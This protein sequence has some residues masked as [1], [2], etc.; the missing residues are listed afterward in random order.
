MRAPG[1]PEPDC[2][3][4]SAYGSAVPDRLRSDGVALLPAAIVLALL[5]YWGAHGGGYAPTT[6][7]PSALVVLGL[8]VA[9]VAGIGPRRLALSRPLLVALAA[10]AAYTA[11]S[12]L[13]IAWADAPGD[14]LEGADRTLLF[15]LLFALFAVLPWRGP[16]AL[17]ALSAFALGVGVLALVTLVRVGGADAAELF[18][19]GRLTSPT[20]YVNGSAALF[21]TGALVAAALASRREL[22]LLLR[23]LLMALATAAVQVAVLCVSRG[24]LFSLPIVLVLAIAVLP[25]RVRFALWALPVA[26]G[27]LAALPALL[28]VFQRFD[29]AEPARA[30]GVLA[31]AA[32][33]AAGTALPACA[34]VL[35]VGLAMAL[36]DRR[37]TVPDRVVRGA[38][39]VAAA[40]AVA[41]A[42]AG[43]AA[44]L[45]AT[46]GRPDRTIAD[47]WDRSQGY[48]SAAPGSSRF[49]LAGSNRPDFWRVS[50]DA[51]AARPLVGLGQD[52]WGEYYVRERHTDEQPRWTHSLEL[53]VLAHSGLVGAL[54]L[55]AFLAAALI[56]ALRGRGRAEPAARAAAAI[57]VLPLVVWTVHGSV[58]WFWEIPALSGP[59][60]AFL[61]LAG[62]LTNPPAREEPATPR[63]PRRDA[64]GALA[65]G[66]GAALVGAAVLLAALALA[67]PYLAER[68]VARAGETWRAA[69][70]AAFDR[71]DRARDLNPLSA[72][73]D[74][75][76]G[77]IALELGEPAIARR[78]FAAAL[79]REQ[80]N[81]F[82]AFARGLAASQ[83]G[84]RAAA[85]ADFLRARALDP[86]EPLVLEA[87]ERVRGARP[88]TAAEAFGSVRQNVERLK[89]ADPPD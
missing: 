35:A 88:L 2:R 77:A 7:L 12:Y 70:S 21:M 44:G 50:L 14:A 76:A 13:S 67:L 5:V 52:N 87:L 8:L 3:P 42:L 86:R 36:V 72:R 55:A 37:T 48:E 43:V 80:R 58:D 85:R 59:A 46:D 47:Y 39:R 28:D 62:A 56:A 71:L 79:E 26:G 57:A 19:D 17:A 16:S 81:W 29:A 63:A 89:G 75:T 31:A 40:L 45:T 11:L 65:A 51:F 54:L 33:H 9:A 6:W 60:F 10:L 18:A 68:D 66:G 32:D 73:P 38:N 49:A 15:L 61:G 4:R 74:L 22:P 41:L 24:W 34:A 82:A 84:E 1:E 78:R 20:D 25:N 69:P 53:R 83:L 30:E 23:P 64:L 27:V